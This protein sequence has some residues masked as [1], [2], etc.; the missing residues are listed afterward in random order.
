MKRAIAMKVEHFPVSYQPH[1]YLIQN[2]SLID[3]A[4]RSVVP[5]V[6]VRVRNGFIDSVHRTGRLPAVQE[7]L[8]ADGLFLMPGLIDLHVHL[9]WDGGPDPLTGMKREGPYRAMARGIANARQSLACGVTTLR[10]LG[11]VDGH[12]RRQNHSAH[13]RSCP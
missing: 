7:R 6:S 5:K 4:A 12:S 13:G 8:T 11:S 2:V 3:T 1:D 10:D 9:V